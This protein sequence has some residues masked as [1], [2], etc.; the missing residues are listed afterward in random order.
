MQILNITPEQASA[1]REIE[2]QEGLSPDLLTHQSE[3]IVYQGTPEEARAVE[4]L[5]NA[6]ETTAAVNRVFMRDLRHMRNQLL[7]ASDVPWKIE[8]RKRER[9]QPN[10]WEEWDDYQQALRNLPQ[11]TRDPM[12]PIWPIKPTE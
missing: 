2:W 12:N 5:F 6:P 4:A 1:K 3:G 9:G 10:K 11:V 8:L 7:K